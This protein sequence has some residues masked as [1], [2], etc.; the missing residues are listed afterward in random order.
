MTS[1]KYYDFLYF[2]KPLLNVLSQINKEGTFTQSVLNEKTYSSLSSRFIHLYFLHLYSMIRTSQPTILVLLSF[3][4]IYLIWGTTYLAIAIGLSGFP[5]FLMAFT[6]FIIAGVV[7]L[8]Y[9]LT[10]GENIPP[11]RIIIHNTIVGTVVL[12]G[13]QGL[14]FWAEQYISSGYAS[15]LIATMPIWFVVFDK[16]HW[17]IYFTNKFILLG[18]ALGFI[19]ILILFKDKLDEPIATE[20]IQLQII[21]SLAVILGAIFW[22]V[23][24][25]Y[26]RS[27]PSRGS[28]AS[29]LSWQ[30]IGGSL[31]CL[32]FSLLLEE[33][34]SFQIKQV[35]LEAWLAVL[36][37]ALAGSVIA[38]MAYTWLMQ[39]MPSAIVGTYAYINPIIAVVAGIF[40]AGESLSPNQ[41]G[42][43]MV[44]LA[45]AV[46]VNVNRGKAQ[47]GI[48]PNAKNS[49]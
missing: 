22:A 8:G 33:T 19:G 25:L 49:L 42:G 16:S 15:V 46:L 5:P 2:E 6:R 43:M 21:A 9:V 40:I 11:T 32:L 17:K 20:D 38:F 3:A 36:Y 34:T 45:S 37:L 31:V 30:L 41:I 26:Y 12:V 28:M 10:K 35:S 24:T 14:L 44:I 18:I 7:L 4:A 29:N 27:K 48:T 39:K 1:F 13:G 23:G 47:Q